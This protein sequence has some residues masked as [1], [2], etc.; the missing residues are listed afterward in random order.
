MSVGS[1]IDRRTL[2]IG[3]G[4]GIGLVVAWGLWPRE[5]GVSVA[6]GASETVYNGWVKIGRDGQ[7]T[8]A[9]PQSE[10]GQGVYTVLPQ[11]VADEL[12]AD[13]RTVGVEAAPVSP[14]YANPLALHEL[15]ESRFDAVP[16]DL[17][18][19][20]AERSTA[21]LT[22]GSTSVRMFEEPARTA[23]A[24]ARV[25]LCRAAAAGWDVDWTE[26]SVAAGFV[27]HAGK[28]IRFADLAETAAG[29]KL[30]DPVPIGTQGAG[31]LTG[32]DVPR[33]DAPAKVDGSANFTGDI[34]LPD[35][36]HAAIRQGPI[37]GP[38]GDSRLI[39]VDRAAAERIR[40]V[41]SV[42][43]T[44]RWVAAVATTSWAAERALEAMR[45]RFETRGGP[46]DSRSIDAA[47]QGAFERPGTRMTSV[48]D[49]SAAF[50]SARLMTASY[51]AS[52][53]VHAAIETRSATAAYRDGRLELWLQTQAPAR[54]RSAA[55]LA[56]GI[57]EDAVVIHPLMIGGS[58]GIALEHD[59]AEQAAVLA[60][61]LK[62][63]VSL[64][65]SRGEDL[66]QDRYRPPAAARMTARLAPGG[67]ILG[68]QARIA[69]PATGQA[70]ARR[71]VPGVLETVVETLGGG[72][73][74]AVAGALPP[75]R[76]PAVAVDHHPAEIGIET[77]HLRGG[78][79]GYTAF[80][81]ESFLDELAHAGGSEPVSFR[82]GMLGGNPRLARCLSTA[83]A[84][85]GWEGG[86]AGSGQG[87]AAHAFRGSFIAVLAEAH[88]GEDERPV[89]DRLVAAVDCG[90]TINPDIVR[91][92]IEGGLIFGLAQAIGA[93]TGFT[94]NLAD[95]KRL[96]DLNLPVLDGS[97]DITVELIPSDAA[98]GGVSE[99]AVPPVAPAIGNALRAA[100]GVRI[101]RLP[102]KQLT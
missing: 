47:L 49:I 29:G 36:V 50:A 8:V 19:T 73:G 102:L 42:V 56:A 40:G 46:I 72:D 86:V 76:I 18:A 22:G 10:H 12:G 74:Y 11:I 83:A 37:G 17:R 84:L 61:K 48:G 81:T 85:G 3:G 77:G 34:R 41:L 6:A 5:Y 99:L 63:P 59:A 64:I 13:W 65:W 67:A 62:R 35:M 93:S 88:L 28:R 15:F 52:A 71:I 21:M 14:L 87:V 54:A 90:R 7:V 43:E 26:C 78:A 79:H 92:Q 24:A 31:R 27:V 32:T 9:V 44:P 66:R 38:I 51:Q 30:P 80:F 94:R 95:A 60:V 2:L 25:L 45:P 57:A 16:A 20:Y 89:V 58:F 96:A 101:R 55:A 98:P 100:T 82:I 4:A 69:A 39:R 1:R 68:W 53:G 91:Q 75:Y 23:G 70:L 33:L 97:P